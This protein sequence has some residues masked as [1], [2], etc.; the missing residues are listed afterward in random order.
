MGEEKSK[1]SQQP[2]SP[3]QF[4]GSVLARR[5][6]SGLIL[7]EF[8]HKRAKKLPQHSHQ[9]AFF[10]LLLD[11]DYQESYGKRTAVLQ[12]LTTIFHPS[13]VTHHDEIGPHGIRIFSVEVEDQ[14]VDRLREYGAV[15]ESSVGLPGGE[16]GWLA[17]RLYRE[18]RA[19]HC[20]SPI[21]I[22][23]LVLEMLALVARARTPVERKAPAWLGKAEDFLKAGFPQRMSISQVA[24]EVGVHP[25]YLSKVFR[26]FHHQ[27]IG[28]YLHKLRV[29]FACE[30][31]L[32]NDEFQL[33]TIAAAAGF[34]DQS[35]FT[36]VF[37][38]LTG[39]TPGTFRA[40]FGKDARR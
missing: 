38:G 12:P 1:Q 15:P 4:Y 10:N 17:T 5:K 2:L 26:Q 27:S 28:D 33:A 25:V 34:A 21:A 11:G 30:M 35:H 19:H 14:W 9:L 16:L 7:S 18:Y 13:G 36:R 37:K 32:A 6:R 8:E 24:Q 22:E 23:G 3:G 31:L 29:Q 40:Q 39:L 20:C